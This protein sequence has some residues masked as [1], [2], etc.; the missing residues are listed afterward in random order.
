MSSVK[1]YTCLRRYIG[2]CGDGCADDL[3]N[4]LC[5][6]YYPCHVIGSS[7]VAEQPWRAREIQSE[8]LRRLEDLQKP[9]QKSEPI[10]KPDLTLE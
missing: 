1:N 3:K 10:V 5:P 4:A 2:I 6:N 7:A 8:L 9:T